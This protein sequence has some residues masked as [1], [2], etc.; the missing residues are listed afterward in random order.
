MSGIHAS[1]NGEVRLNGNARLSEIASHPLI[2]SAYVLLAEA[3]AIEVA[4]RA[5]VSLAHSLG[6][7]T[8]CRTTA[9]GV[10]CALNGTETCAAKDPST[11]IHAILDG[12]PCWRSYVSTIGVALHAL[13][14]RLEYGEGARSTE[15]V[16]VQLPC[17]SANGFQ[18]LLRAPNDA[19]GGFDTLSVAAVRRTDGDVRL[20]IGGVAPH[21]YRVYNSVEEEA[22]AGGL[23]DETIAGLAERALLDAEPDAAS[24]GKVDAAAA[25]LRAAI[26]EIAA[27]SP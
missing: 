3:C 23:D 12:G 1:D 8:P 5:D 18:H 13:D 25:L 16:E 21:P 24:I 14:G 26:E 20:V 2:R 10:T 11:S 9:N 15:V 17:E 19:V 27:V 22:M 7:V 4:A 6:P